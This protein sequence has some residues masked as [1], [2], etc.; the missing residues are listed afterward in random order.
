MKF[1][2]T[3]GWRAGSAATASRAAV[4]AV[5]VVAATALLALS[6][7]G[8]GW[9][10]PTS[11]VGGASPTGVRIVGL[12]AAAAGAALLLRRRRSFRTSG[13]RGSDPAAEGLVTAAAVMALLFALSLLAPRTAP[14]DS[15]S[16]PVAA[17]TA[18]PPTT[19]E[20]GPTPPRPSPV[21]ES[22]ETEGSPLLP[23]PPLPEPEPA[24]QDTPVAEPPPTGGLDWNLLARVAN[25]L[26]L[27]LLVGAVA[28]GLWG[29][30]PRL[31][32]AGE[33]APEPSIGAD[34]AEAGLAASLAHVAREGDGPRRQ[35]TE[36]YR[37]LLDVLAEAGARREPYE[38][39]HEHLGRALGPLGVR[40]EPLRRL[41]ELYVIAQFSDHPVDD[42]D[43][44]R[45]AEAL[46]ESLAGL[47]K[48]RTTP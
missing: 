7:G 29:L 14:D 32:R 20:P 41:T 17:A 35:I 28:V 18:P 30:V 42:A 25:G 48:A 11:G 22:T 10:L 27:L 31:R 36:A 1:V 46:E 21:G 45:A 23:N 4:A 8:P 16:D 24:Q 38:A 34:E 26:L 2:S 43:R 39:P 5:L 37:R 6:T 12:V 15:G 19:Q 3:R 44:V 33:I 40:P 47:R 9:T 13:G